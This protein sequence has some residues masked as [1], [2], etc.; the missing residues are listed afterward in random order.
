MW[1]T[2]AVLSGLIRAS[3]FFS[4]VDDPKKK[5][6][7]FFLARKPRVC[8]RYHVD[9]HVVKM[10]L[11]TCQL[12]F[13]CWHML[14]PEHRI[15]RPAYKKTHSNHP[16]ARWVRSS[17]AHY[18]WLCALGVALCAEYTRRYG[19]IHKCASHLL[20]LGNLRL[21]IDVHSWTD[22]PLC[23]D[24]EY[25][26]ENA[27]CSYRLYYEHAKKHLHSW[28]HRDPPRWIAKTR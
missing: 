20:K 24:E 21:P 1:P 8:A 6:N 10:I 23:M 3:P 16:C 9:K 28:S 5:M 15:I 14:D 17:Q 12:L 25:K 26:R 7:I 22:P 11:E 27:V 13:T 19:K 4:S 18:D 2:F